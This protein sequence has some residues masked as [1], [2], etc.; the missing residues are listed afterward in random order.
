MSNDY[1]RH[2]KEIMARFAE[3]CKNFSETQKLSPVIP[4]VSSAQP[5]L[6]D[7][8]CSFRKARLFGCCRGNRDA[9]H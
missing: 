6:I 2:E 1:I 7:E 4:E 8:A 5:T 9:R 3:R